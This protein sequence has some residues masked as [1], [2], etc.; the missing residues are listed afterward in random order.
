MAGLSSLSIQAAIATEQAVRRAGAVL[1][2]DTDDALYVLYPKKITAE[3]TQLC[4]DNAHALERLLRV[5]AA[6]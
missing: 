5:R 4:K 1:F 2:V 6:P 3:L